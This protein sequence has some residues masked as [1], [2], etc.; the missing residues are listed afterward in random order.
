MSLPQYW[1]LS[2][3]SLQLYHR[4]C[5]EKMRP[6]DSSS[7]RRP[8][9]NRR[10]RQQSSRLYA[11]N[12]KRGRHDAQ[13]FIIA[14]KLLL[15]RASL[16][17]GSGCLAVK[18]DHQKSDTSRCKLSQWWLSIKTVLHVPS[19]MCDGATKFAQEVAQ[20]KIENC[21]LIVNFKFL[22]LLLNISWNN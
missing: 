14:L 6:R 18:I 11:M 7:L 10:T 12:Y 3:V 2:T 21:K 5:V 8:I 22:I 20:L 4:Y 13:C 15:Y 19:S 16:P 9:R 1:Y 17:T